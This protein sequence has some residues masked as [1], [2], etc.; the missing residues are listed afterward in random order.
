MIHYS[1]F[2]GRDNRNSYAILRYILKRC[3]YSKKIIIS[4]EDDSDRIVKQIY[5]PMD[6]MQLKWI[7]DRCN[8]L[9][10]KWYCLT[11][12]SY[13]LLDWINEYDLIPET[14]NC[15][16]EANYAINEYGK[17]IK[18]KKG[19]PIKVK[20]NIINKEEDYLSGADIDIMNKVIRRWKLYGNIIVKINHWWYNNVTFRKK[21]K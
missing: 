8:Y 17:I 7:I 3:C 2:L 15:D 18:N 16:W 12:L 20:S 14:F 13:D 9:S 21:E 5:Q 19:N 1:D 10:G 11:F 6:F 4:E